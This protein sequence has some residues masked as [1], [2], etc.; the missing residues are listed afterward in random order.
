[1]LH[2]YDGDLTKRFEIFWLEFDTYTSETKETTAHKPK[3]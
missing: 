3:A 2:F 1:M